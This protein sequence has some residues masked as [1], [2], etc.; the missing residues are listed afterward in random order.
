[1]NIQILGSFITVPDYLTLETLETQSGSGIT[2]MHFRSVNSRT[3]LIKHLY[4]TFIFAKCFIIIFISCFTP[5]ESMK[6]LQKRNLDLEEPKKTKFILEE[7]TPFS[8][9]MPDTLNYFSLAI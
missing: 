4:R 6:N 5:K 1:M 2:C 7:I 8:Y 3:G 9:N